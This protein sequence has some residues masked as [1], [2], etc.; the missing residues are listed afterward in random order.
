MNKKQDHL[1]TAENVYNAIVEYKLTHDGVA[2]AYR[3]L[4]EVT[5][6]A[7]TGH[8][9]FIIYRL[10]EDGRIILGDGVRTIQLPRGRWVHV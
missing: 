4:C 3:E 9:K 1:Q 5:G 6:I 7:S 8:M 2:P 10:A